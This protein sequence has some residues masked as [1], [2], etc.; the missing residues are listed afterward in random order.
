VITVYRLYDE[1]DQLL[2]VGKTTQ[3]Q[4]RIDQHRRTQ[5]WGAE[6]KRWE[7]ETFDTDAAASSEERRLFLTAGPA[8]NKQEPR[9]DVPEI[10]TVVVRM[11]RG[12]YERLR[13]VADHKRRTVPGQLRWLAKQAIEEHEREEAA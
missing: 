13:R 11:Q 1:N 7:V 6:I 8:Y 12:Q 9:S 10:T 3:L 5:Q 2:Y 4:T